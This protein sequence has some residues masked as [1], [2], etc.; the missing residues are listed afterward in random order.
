VTFYLPPSPED[1]SAAEGIV[2][3]TNNEIINNDYYPNYP[4]GYTPPQ[5]NGNYDTG[6]YGGD[7]SG[8]DTIAPP[9]PQLASSPEWLAYLNSLGLQQDQFT[10]DIQRQ[11]GVAQAAAAQQAADITAQGPQE[12][13]N[14]TGGLETRG[15]ARSGQLVRTLAEQRAGEGRRQAA[16]QSGLAQNL[17]QLESQLSNKMI[18]LGAKR[19]DQELSLRSQG[20]Q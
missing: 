19:A 4:Y 2:S 11:R 1:I 17:S 15:M 6:T 12:R 13:R 20:Y 8:G 9:R 18:E 10:A 16:V 3:D 7:G 5:G 14:I